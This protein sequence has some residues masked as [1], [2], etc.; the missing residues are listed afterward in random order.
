MAQK[1][2]FKKTTTT[3][4]DNTSVTAESKRIIIDFP[5]E[6]STIQGPYYSFRIGAPEGETVDICINQGDWRPCR[7]ASGY[8]W[9][10]WSGFEPGDYK[11]VARVKVAGQIEVS[12][13]RAFKV[14]K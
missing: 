4:T 8:W 11:V 3:K 2:F 10:D 12:K 5:R 7:R 14:S 6:S 13:P 9:F 1:L